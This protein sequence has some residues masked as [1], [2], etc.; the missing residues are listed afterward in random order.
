MCYDTVY[1]IREDKAERV[2]IVDGEGA[3]ESGAEGQIR[4]FVGEMDGDKLFRVPGLS[5]NGA[6]HLWIYHVIK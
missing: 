6:D 3:K 2:R 5:M 4:S 1:L